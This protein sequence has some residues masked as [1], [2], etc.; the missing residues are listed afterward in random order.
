MDP[1]E[2]QDWKE[3]TRRTGSIGGLW[4]QDDQR[5][6]FVFTFPLKQQTEAHSLERYFRL[7]LLFFFPVR[8]EGATRGGGHTN[9]SDAHSDDSGAKRPN[10]RRT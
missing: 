8:E 5:G 9:V 6:F 1:A 2:A 4:L 7:L 3:R 10:W